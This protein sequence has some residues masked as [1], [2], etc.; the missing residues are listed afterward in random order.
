VT[1]DS[2]SNIRRSTLGFLSGTLFSR[3]S[4]LLREITFAYSFGT[5]ASL[6]AFFIAFRFAH[7]ARRLL[8]ES[9]LQSAFI[10][11]F[12]E[13]RMESPL[14]SY[15][16]YRDLT[17]S[18]T[19]LLVLLC[20]TFIA[21]IL[22][23]RHICSPSTQEI[24]FF[25]LLI[26]PSLVPTCLFALNTSV[27]QSKGHYFL[28]A[29]SPAYFN[30]V[31]ICSAILLKTTP[32]PSA[33]PLLCIG[34]SL[35]CTAQWAASFIP[36][37]R[38]CYQTLG[39]ELFKKIRLFS[40]AIRS[41]FKPLSLT[42]LGVGASQINSALD[43][44]FARAA[45]SQ[46]PAYLWFAIRFQQLP[47]ALFAIALSSAILPP[48]TRARESDDRKAFSSFLSFGLRQVLATLGSATALFYLLAHP[49]IELVYG[50]GQFDSSSV[51]AT[52]SC[53]RAYLLGLVPMGA[54]LVLAQAFY[55][56][57]EYAIPSKAAILS[58]VIN[59]AL[60]SLFIFGLGWSS[61]S[62][63]LS[64]SFSAWINAF[65]L[66]NKLRTPLEEKSQAVRSFLCIASA[67]TLTWYTPSNSQPLPTLITSG[68][69][70][71]LILLSTAFISKSKDLLWKTAA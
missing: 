1:Q 10:P 42:L 30:I 7:L 50:H 57:K 62:V 43:T 9:S 6:A 23:F 64:T 61:E 40:P 16:L 41:I 48:L 32:I 25:S 55:A 8:G 12:E 39:S 35:A 70:F 5:H 59:I 53:L 56:Q 58:L 18:W 22:P 33:M 34:M 47:L 65:Y 45:E 13:K 21:M 17:L 28:S 60:N 67:T 46:G 69:L 63:A 37:A 14:E 44:L 19:L 38:A 3:I 2:V 49:M 20:L 51:A 31:L 15:R 66:Y 27:L 68:S 26:I 36:V 24:L 52:A 54:T 71:A 29:V 4:G 11:I